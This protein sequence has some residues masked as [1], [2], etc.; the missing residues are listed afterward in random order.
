MQMP[1]WGAHDPV[2]LH[3]RTYVHMQEGTAIAAVLLALLLN[4]HYVAFGRPVLEGLLTSRPVLAVGNGLFGVGVR[5]AMSAQGVA[6]PDRTESYARGLPIDIYEPTV[7]SESKRPVVLYFHSGAFIGGHRSMGAG[8]CAWLASHGA[9]CMSASYRR[10]GSGAG[11]VG[12][13]EDAWAALRWMR[14][15]VRLR[16]RRVHQL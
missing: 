7:Q 9:V 12:C 15:P 10:T 13:I 3:S 2:R 6:L 1:S 14:E 16:L 8:M 4:L 11:V 5:R